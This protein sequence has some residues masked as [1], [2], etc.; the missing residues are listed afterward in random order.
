MNETEYKFLVTKNK[1][2]SILSGIKSRYPEARISEKIQ[3]NY[4]YDTDDQYLMSNH[5]TLRIRQIENKLTLQ[6]KESMPAFKDFSSSRETCRDIK[7]LMPEITLK[8]GRYAWIPFALQG[9]LTTKRISISPEKGLSIDFDMN[10]YLGICDFEI[11][12][13]FK[14]DCEKFTAD[15]VDDMKLMTFKNQSGGKAYRFFAAKDKLLG[16]RN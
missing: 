4:Y 3:I 1:F 14:T 16:G 15:L 6:M 2:Y 11:E 12:M 8:E 5:T 10:C 13:E 7:C 9:S